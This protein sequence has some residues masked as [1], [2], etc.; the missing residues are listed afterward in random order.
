MPECG[1]DVHSFLSISRVLELIT[2][3]MKDDHLFAEANF[4][5]S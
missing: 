1:D 2:L 4:S 5:S 3:S